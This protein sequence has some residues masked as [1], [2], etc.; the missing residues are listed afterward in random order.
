MYF[1][2]SVFF[3][4]RFHS[5][6]FFS[7]LP[8]FFS[9]IGKILVL[10]SST[11]DKKSSFADLF[12]FFGIILVEDSP[13]TDLSDS[14]SEACLRILSVSTELRRLPASTVNTF[15][16]VVFFRSS[17]SGRKMRRDFCSK[18]SANFLLICSYSVGRQ[19]KT[20]N[21]QPSQKTT[22]SEPAKSD[23]I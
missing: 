23:K 7:F 3:F 22:S 10:F 12:L 11:V 15:C 16:I 9:G 8:L 5:S 21:K 4:N 18:F 6:F 1:V 2:F 13:L 20:R 17:K 19:K 14:F